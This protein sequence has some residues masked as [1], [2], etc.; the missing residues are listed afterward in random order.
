MTDKKKIPLSNDD[1]ELI[2]GALGIYEIY[3][4]IG[5]VK[6]SYGKSPRTA[7][8]VKKLDKRMRDIHFG[9]GNT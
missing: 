6:C 1:R 3:L 5:S 9:K 7:K 8:D 4:R 2:L